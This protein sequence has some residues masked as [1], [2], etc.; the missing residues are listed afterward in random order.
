MPETWPETNPEETPTPV[1]EGAGAGAAATVAAAVPPQAPTVSGSAIA[2][3]ENANSSLELQLN[4][5]S[6]MQQ[7]TGVDLI[8]PSLIHSMAQLPSSAVHPLTT[9]QPLQV[10]NDPF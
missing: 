6:Q 5:L 4:Q 10:K 2:A 1:V 9:F 3:G 8:Q 7:A